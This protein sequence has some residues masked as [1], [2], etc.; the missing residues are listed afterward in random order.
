M[1]VFDVQ[2]TLVNNP[3]VRDEDIRKMLLV[4]RA[5][6][7]HLV[8]MTGNLSGVPTQLRELVDE[9]WEKPISF[10]ELFN[11]DTV[12][13]DDCMHILQAAS[14]AGAKIVHASQMG[15]WIANEGWNGSGRQDPA[16]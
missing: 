5:A 1:Y 12:V 2:G 15:D 4:L 14:H 11:E 13:F 8:I 16:A 6:G 10:R 7:H 9:C 3:S